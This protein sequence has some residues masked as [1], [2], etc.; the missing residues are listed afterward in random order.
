MVFQLCCTLNIS[1]SAVP[2]RHVVFH[3]THFLF[4]FIFFFLD[5]AVIITTSESN[6]VWLQCGESALNREHPHPYGVRELIKGIMEIEKKESF[7]KLL[8]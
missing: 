6:F 4:L 7:L 2:F 8:Y 1:V 3:L 5:I